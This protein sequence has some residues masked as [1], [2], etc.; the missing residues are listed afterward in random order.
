MVLSVV[1][2]ISILFIRSWRA[3]EKEKLLMLAKAESER[4][5]ATAL[6]ERE[7]TNA[8]AQG[9]RAIT[10]QIGAIVMDVHN[11]SS[12]VAVM[13]SKIDIAFDAL[14]LTPRPA[15]PPQPQQPPPTFR[16]PSSADHEQPG[17]DYPERADPVVPVHPVKKQTPPTGLST[18]YSHKKVPKGG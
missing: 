7:R 3:N 4:T 6:A 15:Y 12:T 1:S 5:V 11:L 14:D 10:T 18:I 2:T 17:G 8:I 9:F 13:D 16:L